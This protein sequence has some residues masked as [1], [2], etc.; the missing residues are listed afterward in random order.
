MKIYVDGSG[1]G[2]YAFVVEEPRDVKIFEKKNITNNE[3]EYLAVIEA[4]R[5]FSEREIDIL[6]DSK[7]IVDQLN[8]KSAIKED[9][10]RKLAQEVWN[11][12]KGR[13]VKFIWIPRNENKAGKVL[14]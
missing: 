4:L 1:E 6:S 13:N 7:L 14:G 2:K 5:N 3:A 12:A 11:L 9:R 10:L 8:M